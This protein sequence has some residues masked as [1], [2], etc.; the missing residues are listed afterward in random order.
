MMEIDCPVCSGG[1]GYTDMACCGNYTENGE[2][3]Q[4]CVIPEL[5]QCD[6]CGGCG[7][8]GEIKLEDL[9]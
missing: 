7:K 4:F 6:I 8:V 9:L 1:G 2:C 3:K 5:R